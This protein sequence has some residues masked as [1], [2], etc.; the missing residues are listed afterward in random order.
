MPAGLWAADEIFRIAYNTSAGAYRLIDFRNRTG[1][2][3][4]Y[5]G[6]TAPAGS[7]L[8]FGQAISRTAYVGLFT[9][10]GTA[11]GVGDGTT[12]FNLPDL[13]GRV[14]AGKTNMGGSDNGLLSGFSGTTLGGLGGSQ[15]I[16][17]S[18]AGAT[19]MDGPNETS[20][21][22]NVDASPVP[23]ASINHEHTIH[24]SHSHIQP[25]IILNYLI[26]I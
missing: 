23:S 22:Q 4:P 19:A 9:A 10:L 5:A 2:V 6:A 21:V 20:N 13:R 25:T 18:Q 8:C 24:I 14:A 12:T 3:V 7:L 17:I 15:I 26:R 11:H 16:T 1:E